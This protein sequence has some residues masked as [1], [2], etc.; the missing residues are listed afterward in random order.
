MEGGEVVEEEEEEGDLESMTKAE[1]QD[2]ARELG[3]EGYSSM[4]KAEL[5]EAIQEAEG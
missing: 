1:L 5:V 4:N 3:V 2:R